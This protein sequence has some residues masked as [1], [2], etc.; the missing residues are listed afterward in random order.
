MSGQSRLVVSF[1]SFGYK[2][3]DEK[4]S[5]TRPDSIHSKKRVISD[6]MEEGTRKRNSE[7]ISSRSPEWLTSR[8]PGLLRDHDRP[9]YAP[10]AQQE[11]RIQKKKRPS[12]SI[13]LVDTPKAVEDERLAYREQKPARNKPRL[14]LLDDDLENSPLEG[15]RFFKSKPEKSVAVSRALRLYH[16]SN[17]PRRESKNEEVTDLLSDNDSQHASEES[18]REQEDFVEDLTKQDI[19]DKAQKIFQTCDGFT[20][21]LRKELRKWEHDH[22]K[23]D[24]GCIDLTSIAGDGRHLLSQASFAQICP[25]LSLKPYQIVG[26]NWM[27]LLHENGMNGVLADDMGLGKTVQTIAFL[28]YLKSSRP[29]SAKAKPHLLVVPASTLVNWENEF[30]R[31]C[32]SLN[33]FLYHGNQ[34]ERSEMRHV[35]RGQFERSSIDVLLCTYT[36]FERESGADDRK[37]L[38]SQSFEY[39]VLD[40]AH[41]I[42]NSSSSRFQQLNRIKTKH[43][44]LLSGTPVQNDLRE[45]LALLSFL[46]PDVF[47][48]SDCE[49]LLDAFGMKKTDKNG[50]SSSSLSKMRSIL[51]PF[52]LRRLK[53]DVLNQ[54]VDKKVEYVRLPMTTFQKSV[55][56][57]IMQSYAFRKA[58][59]MESLSKDS[60]EFEFDG[61][62]LKSILGASKESNGNAASTNVLDLTRVEIDN[63]LNRELT[64]SEANHLFTALRK[65][66][67]HPLLLRVRFGE[68]AI[69]RRVAE[70]AFKAGHFGYQCD[71]NMVV[72]EL[73]SQSDFDL[74]QI[75]L[76]Y[77]NHLGK[78]PNELRSSFF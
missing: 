13:S 65:A 16:R 77:E 25:S 30:A 31:F 70:I 38:Q 33:V 5:D 48:Q 57:G 21:N 71:L 49:V 72:N 1:D 8:N 41:S 18:A 20:A 10:S 27:K 29:S 15:R 69:L 39:L 51:A 53:K 6:D 47:K 37:F 50:R 11:P 34:S 35:L 56:F 78:P 60:K 32:P 42:K 17:Q 28:G 64:P 43:R 7:A 14:N 45:L 63:V 67:N 74:H 12:G 23:S 3:V 73:A 55:Y 66:A 2:P 44:L 58:K 46:M 24:S 52:V 36:V 40:E 4:S 68:D 59:R 22:S 26:I 9:L 19:H 75:C 62:S 61:I 76:Q 54:L